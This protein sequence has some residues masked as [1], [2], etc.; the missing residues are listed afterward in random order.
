MYNSVRICIKFY[1]FVT[2]VQSNTLTNIHKC[3]AE[4]FRLCQN[5]T[6]MVEEN[7]ST[8]KIR[9]KGSYEL[10]KRLRNGDLKRITEHFKRPYM[11]VSAIVRGRQYGD[12]NIVECAERIVAYYDEIQIED[13]VT[14]I[15]ESYAPT[16]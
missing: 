13:N 11:T 8:V 16:N 2:S 5:T 14:K 15:I 7:L 9:A 4:R 1:T 10:G 12:A 6:I 3:K